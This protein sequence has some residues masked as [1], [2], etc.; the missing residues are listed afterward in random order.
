ME[1]STRLDAD[2][3]ARRSLCVARLPLCSLLLLSCGS[4]R[5]GGRFLVRTRYTRRRGAW[6][7]RS[8]RMGRC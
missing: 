1:R 4:F 5:S 8:R 7:T 2:T 6:P 3:I